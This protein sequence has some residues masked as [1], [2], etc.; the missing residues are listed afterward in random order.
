MAILAFM[1]DGRLASVGLTEEGE[2]RHA[3]GEGSRWERTEKLRRV[4]EK[5]I[6]LLLC[7]YESRLS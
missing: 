7:L 4:S 3:V 1:S 2:R 5:L 6:V